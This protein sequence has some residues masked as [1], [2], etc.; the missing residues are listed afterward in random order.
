MILRRAAVAS[1]L[2]LVAFPPMASAHGIAAKADLP[3]PAWMFAWA[4]TLVLI[5]SFAAL[6]VLWREPRLS[7]SGYRDLVPLGRWLDVLLGTVGVAWFCLVCWAGLTGTVVATANLAPT[8]VWVAFW[9][10]VP[11]ASA[12]FGDVFRL[13][14][15]WRALAR[16]FGWAAARVVPSG[17][18]EPN[19][20]PERWGCRPAV[21]GLVLMVWIEL[22]Y[23]A[24]RDDP[25]ALATLALVYAALQL[26]G[27]SIWGVETWTARGDS[28]AVAFSLVARISPF[29][30]V[31]GRLRL[32][33]PLADLVRLR[34]LPGTQ[35]VLV[36]V[37]GATTFDGFTQG[38]AW[39]SAQP[40]LAARARDLG[41][42][43]LAAADAASTLGLAASIAVIWGIWTAGVS[44]AASVIGLR[45]REV[46]GAFV[47]LLVPIA[48]AYT[49]AHYASLLIYQGQ[50]LAYLVSDPA[51]NGADWFGSASTSI[52]YSVIGPNGIWWIQV[53]AL[54]A[55]HVAAL[56]V[57]HDRAL[58]LTPDQRV[59]TRSQVP[60]LVATVGFTSLGLWLLSAANL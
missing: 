1:A 35:A 16:G 47:G 5:V 46:A 45:R 25:A 53:A 36:V 43:P 42:A 49:I 26:V 21:A 51:G 28:F 41:F 40:W 31:D 32:R 13:L 27:I 30:R 58:E 3:I 55:G 10:G 59:A 60:M 48:L 11:I 14:S 34:P 18:P 33:V 37:V 38:P 39:A 9:V 44:G 4:A 56:V 6:A 52:D 7:A 20:W 2:L 23:P 22:A 17:L 50:A 54:V 57:A 8:A 19:R 24:W 29:T 12:I 15:P